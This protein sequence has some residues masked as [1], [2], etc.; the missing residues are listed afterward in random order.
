MKMDVENFVKLCLVCQQAKHEHTH[1]G[2]LLQPLP[3]PQGA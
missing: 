2:G 3:V 1:P